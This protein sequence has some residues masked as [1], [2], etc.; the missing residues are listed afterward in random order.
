MRL[1]RALARLAPP[2]RVPCGDLP[3]DSP[4]AQPELLQ[5][6]EHLHH[7]SHHDSAIRSTPGNV[8]A[9]RAERG[10]GWS[11]TPGAEH[12][13][14]L[15]ALPSPYPDTDNGFNIARSIRQPHPSRAE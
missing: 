9:I 12:H 8:A 6:L 7:L 1:P 15:R 4:P 11:L 3:S 14:L 13:R 2:V 5:P 10:V